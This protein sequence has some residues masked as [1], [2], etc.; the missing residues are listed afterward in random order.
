LVEWDIQNLENEQN[1]FTGAVRLYSLKPVNK[2]LS[3]NIN[4]DSSD[5]DSENNNINI[6]DFISDD[7]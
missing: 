6:I 3:D 2:T 5:T 4:F 1:A 7:E